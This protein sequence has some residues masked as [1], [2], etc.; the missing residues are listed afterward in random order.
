MVI[1]V[2]QDSRLP[3]RETEGNPLALG[4]PLA[5]VD[6]VG[7]EGSNLANISWVFVIFGE[8]HL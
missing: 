1:T 6:E 2:A 3:G 4:L 5:G 8:S 7:P